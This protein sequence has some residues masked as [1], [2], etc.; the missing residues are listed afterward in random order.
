KSATVERKIASV[1]KLYKYFAKNNYNINPHAFELEWEDE[2]DTDSVGVLSVQEAITMVELAKEL[3]NGEE[4]SLIIELAY[5]TSIRISAI[6]NIT[7]DKFSFIGNDLWEI[8]IKDKGKKNKKPIFDETYQRLYKAMKRAGEEKVFTL[9][10][11]T[12][13][14]TIKELA[15]RMGISEERKISPHSLKKTMINWTLDQLK[16]VLLAAKQGNH[17]LDVMM[18][19]YVSQNPDYSN[20]PLMLMKKGNDITPL[21]ELSKEELIA[22]IQRASFGTQNE[23]LSLLKQEK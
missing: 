18:K 13:Y 15:K 9:S 1:R 4:K 19:N 5:M 3:P 12:I 7:W 11:T 21:M 6:L 10:Y 20:Y 22:L 8:K 2:D 14:D 16:D 17:S 23:L